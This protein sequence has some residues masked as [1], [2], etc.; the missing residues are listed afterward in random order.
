MRN[1]IYIE[2]TKYAV[3]AGTAELEILER[4]QYLAYNPP[5]HPDEY[6]KWL[7]LLNKE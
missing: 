3:V 5:L 6:M 4:V 7:I 1:R 2:G